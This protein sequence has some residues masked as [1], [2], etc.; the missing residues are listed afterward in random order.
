MYSRS[1]E[2]KSGFPSSIVP[3][4]EEQI[5]IEQAP[6]QPAVGSPIMEEEEEQ[7][8]SAPQANG[9]AQE[10]GD[11]EAG[12]EQQTVQNESAEHG[13]KSEPPQARLETGELYGAPADAS[14][15]VNHDDQPPHARSGKND[16]DEDEEK[17]PGARSVL[18]KHLAA[19][20]GNKQWQLPIPTPR[21][22]PYGFE[23][24]ICDAFWKDVWLTSAAH[25]VSFMRTSEIELERLMFLVM[26]TEIFRKVFHAIPDDLVT[27]W[28]QY[29]E[30]VVHH[31]RLNKPV[32]RLLRSW[33][34]ISDAW[35][36]SRI[37]IP[38]SLPLHVCPQ[39]LRITRR[40]DKLESL[41]T[42]RM[43]LRMLWHEKRSTLTMRTHEALLFP[44]RVRPLRRKRKGRSGR[45][46]RGPSPLIKQRGKRWKLYCGSYEDI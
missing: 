13:E 18:R 41:I 42:T 3:T 1:G 28:K 15:D 2:K 37:T 31:E 46:R 5:I 34:Y 10:S 24:P 12:E 9:H 40:P 38:P 8:G 44:P 30:F 21:V 45:R 25:N 6:R 39:K 17:A 14:T 36:R 19:K 29:K 35:H 43:P 7:N 33:S 20:L 11:T 22:D 26:Q 4:V 16:A 32:R 23:D 27:T